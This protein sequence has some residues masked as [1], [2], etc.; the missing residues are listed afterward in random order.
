MTNEMR[1]ILDGA[2]LGDGCLFISNSSI[3]ADF[4]YTSSSYQHVKYVTQLFSTYSNKNIQFYSRIDNRTGIISNIYRFKTLVSP[5]LT[6]E[7][8]RWYI[9]KEKHIPEDIKLTPL[10]CKIWYLGDGSLINYKNVSKRIDICTNCFEKS[11]IEN[12]LLP[13]LQVFDAKLHYTK[14]KGQM[15]NKNYMITIYKQEN[16]KKFLDYIGDCPFEDYSYKWDFK[17]HERQNYP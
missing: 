11:E 14:N 2:L 12:I 10:V 5:T 13:Q 16:I 17:P 1:E 6:T 8:K 3:N 15:D 7:Q 4:E 9:N